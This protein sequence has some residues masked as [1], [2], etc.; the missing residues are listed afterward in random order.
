[1]RG[2]LAVVGALAARVASAAI[3]NPASLVS[4]LVGSGGVGY[5]IGSL[6]PGPQYPFG[7]MR[8][9]PDTSLGLEPF[10]VRRGGRGAG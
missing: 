10:W 8:V 5:G 4:T 3:P 1:M 9:G 7:A 6:N 2:V